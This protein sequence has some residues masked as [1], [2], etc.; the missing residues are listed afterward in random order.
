MVSVNS[1]K[2]LSQTHTEE[3]KRGGRGGGGEMYIV[4]RSILP[5][6]RFMIKHLRT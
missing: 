5:P 6:I 4:L 1:S 3:E 2:R